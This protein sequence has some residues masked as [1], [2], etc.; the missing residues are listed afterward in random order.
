MPDSGGRPQ[1]G[2]GSVTLIGKARGI[3]LPSHLMT[4]ADF[5]P[6]CDKDETG[7]SGIPERSAVRL[8]DT[9]DLTALFPTPADWTKAFNALQLEYPALTEFRGKIGQSAETLRDCL[10]LEKKLSLQIERLGHYASLRSSE[11]SSDAENLAREGQFENLMTLIGEAASFVAPEIQAIE[12]PLF[13]LYVASPALAEWQIPLQKLRRQKPHTLSANEERLLALG[14]SALR[15]HSETFS[16]LTNVDMKFGTLVDEKGVERPLSQSSFSSFLVKRDAELRK[17]AFHQ[18]YAE[19][20]D[21]KFTLAASLANSIKADVFSARARNHP[22][23]REAALFADDVPVSVYDNLIST[24][25][26]NLQ[27]L[28]RCYELRKR[29]LKLPE[30]H[31]YD[32]YVP[33]VAN[34]ETKVSFDEATEKV[35]AALKPLGSEYCGVLAE[36]LQRK[37][38]CDRFENKGKRSG[39]FS[40]SSYGNPPFILM[41]YKEDVFS[42][43]YTLAHEAGHSMHTW[44][45]QRMQPFQT[46]DYP[47]F[48]AEVA[49]TFNEELL[50]HFL[51]E[52][53]EDPQMRAFLIN[54]QIDDIRGTV[55]RQTMFA[56]FEKVAHAME[57]AG[58]P[59]TL[60]SFQKAY[61]ELLEA[62]FGPGFSIDAELELECLRIPH[63]YNAFYVYKYATG[64]S[65]ATALAEQVLGGSDVEKYL[66]FLRSGG[67]RFPI[68]TLQAAGVDMSSAEPIASALRLFAR[69]VEELEQL[70]G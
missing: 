12:D 56:E 44:Y 47:I 18:F 34:I 64:I 8:E 58:E 53:T 63:F 59:L 60:D 69:R 6:L 45:A 62:Y 23:A 70:V 50:T 4:R 29:V 31:H 21:H 54:R 65:A 19:F 61:R 26:E 32:T 68:P 17:R 46:Y 28:F 1:E 40:S 24:V 41:N 67:S 13:N 66:G 3:A 15:G 30:I 49:S 38:W 25:R 33:I 14:H 48:L 16:Q 39:A 55:Y 10:E 11:D 43:I 7:G 2:S 52:E 42:D 57:E 35:M 5:S 36:G 20:A 22:S 27:P 37:R 9:W 51:L